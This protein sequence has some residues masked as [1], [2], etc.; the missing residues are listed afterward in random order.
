MRVKTFFFLF[1]FSFLFSCNFISSDVKDFNFLLPEKQFTVDSAQFGMTWE[2]MLPAIDCPEN[3]CPDEA[4]FFCDNGT[5]A[6][7]AEYVLQ[8]ELVRLKQEVEELA[9]VGAHDHVTVKFKYIKLEVVNNT[10]TFDL[11]PLRL[12]VAPQTSTSMFD[13]D[14]N[15]RSDVELVGTL[16]SVPAAA[17]GVFDMQLSTQG[18]AALTR[19]CQKPDVP[20]YFYIHGSTIFSAG[21]AVPAGAMTLKIHSMATASIN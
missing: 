10:L 4:A 7:K 19:Y 3:P 5:C 12:Y 6:A 2:G 8:S 20:F 14:G 15:I 13:G 16:E 21:D 1:G 17:T 11:P 9:V 18:E